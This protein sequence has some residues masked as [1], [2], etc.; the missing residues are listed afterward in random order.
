M[1]RMVLATV[2]PVVGGGAGFDDAAFGEGAGCWYCF[3]A[4]V[5]AVADPPGKRMIFWMSAPVA[6]V[7]AVAPVDAAGGGAGCVG[8]L[9]LLVLLL[10]LLL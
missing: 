9:R 8:V 1:R 10:L 3:F 7:A 5:A 4:V 2:A 6:G